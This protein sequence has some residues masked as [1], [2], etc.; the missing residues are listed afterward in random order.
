VF[1]LSKEE[2]PPQVKVGSSTNRKTTNQSPDKGVSPTKD[3]VLSFG[4]A[5]SQ[6]EESGT[7]YL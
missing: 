4:L 3:G 5:S 7:K 6:Y 1:I 2:G